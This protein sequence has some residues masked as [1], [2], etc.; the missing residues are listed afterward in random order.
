[1]HILW[2]IGPVFAIVL[3]LVILDLSCDLARFCP[4]WREYLMQQIEERSKTPIGISRRKR[5]RAG[6]KKRDKDEL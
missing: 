5:K 2:L 6:L 4:R 3:I 1:M